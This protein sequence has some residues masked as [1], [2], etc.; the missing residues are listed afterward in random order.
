[1]GL[2]PFQ[3]NSRVENQTAILEIGGSIDEN[4]QFGEI[5]VSE[6][7]VVKLH[8]VTF[9][10][11]VG[12]RSWCLWLQKFRSPTVVNLEGCPPIMVKSFSVVKNFLT[13]RCIVHSFYVPFYSEATGEHL[14]FLAE[15]NVHFDADG[16]IKIPEIKDS[17][18]QAMEMDVV[19]E[20]Y[21]AFLK[22]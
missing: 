22:K 12:T 15:R 1:M 11:S 14:D 18:G 21:F 7:V 20:S 4:A 5:R 8:K 9:L 3:F 10:N 2:A 17:K 16:R 19:P 6:K 13:D